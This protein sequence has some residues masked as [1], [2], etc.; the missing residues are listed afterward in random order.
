MPRQ[1]RSANDSKSSI[2]TTALASLAVVAAVLAALFFASS[3]AAPEGTWAS[4]Q[5]LQTLKRA[6]LAASVADVAAATRSEA[7]AVAALDVMREDLFVGSWAGVSLPLLQLTQFAQ[8]E[9]RLRLLFATLAC[10]DKMAFD[11]SDAQRQHTVAAAYK[12]AYP[13]LVGE[14]Q[15]LMAEQANWRQLERF[16]QLSPSTSN[17]MPGGDVPKGAFVQA[18]ASSQLFI[19]SF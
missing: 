15:V 13:L 14:S 10:L 12:Q 3:P 1:A 17:G 6:L 11:G 9:M 8:T 19:I 4:T 5:L 2:L 18:F 7:A 16:A